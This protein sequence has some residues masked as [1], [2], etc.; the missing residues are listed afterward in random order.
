MHK[1]VFAV[2]FLMLLVIT[3]CGASESIPLSEFPDK[4][5]KIYSAESNLY[6]KKI[7]INLPIKIDEGRYDGSKEDFGTIKIPVSYIRGRESTL[8]S[9]ILRTSTNIGEIKMEYSAWISPQKPE[10]YTEFEFNNIFGIQYSEN[11]KEYLKIRGNSTYYFLIECTPSD[12]FDV[13]TFAEY[14]CETIDLH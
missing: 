2:L 6:G 8:S 1:K 12:E 10:E 4:D 13:D 7:F 3:G 5:Y 9:Y 14:F 11:D